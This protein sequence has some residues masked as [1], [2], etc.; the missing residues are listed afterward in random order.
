MNQDTFTLSRLALCVGL[1]I[2]PAAATAAQPTDQLNVVS[3][4]Q[5]QQA[6]SYVISLRT[7]AAWE[8][9]G[10][11]NTAQKAQENLLKHIRSLDGNAKLLAS[12]TKL[13]N[14]MEL[15]LSAKA[16]ETLKQHPEVAAIHV[17][18]QP[19]LEVANQNLALQSV[20]AD[21]LAKAYSTAAPALSSD[22]NAGAGVTIAILS[23][24][25]DY[26]HK[27]LGGDGTAESYALARE[28]AGAPFDGFPTEVV[29]GGLDVSP[30][31]GW[32][33]DLNPLDQNDEYIDR[34]GNAYPTGRGTMLASLVRQ[35][36]PGAKLM[37]YKVAGMTDW[38]RPSYPSQPQIA[39]AMEHAVESGADIIIIDNYLYGGHF[40]AYFDP[41]DGQS[42]GSQG[43]ISMINAAA[44]KGALVVTTAGYFGQFPSKYNIGTLGA[45]ADALTVGGVDA[46]GDLLMTSEWTPHGPVRGIG[47][48]KPDVVSYN[49]EMEVARVGA[50]DATLVDSMPD[51]AVARIA[52][53]AAIVKGARDGLSSIEVKALLANT[54]SHNIQRGDS[55]QNASVTQI[56]SGVENIDAAMNSPL[57]VWEKNSYQPSLKFGI[58]EVDGVHRITKQITL[59]NLS[60][61]VQT[62]SLA[63]NVAEHHAETTGFRWEL[64]A[65]VTIPA[66]QSISVPV[67]LELNSAELPALGLVETDDY[68]IESWERAEISGYLT[69]TS[70]DKPALNLGWAVMPRA[71][72]SIK[73]N[74]ETYAEVFSWDH[75]K[76]LPWIGTNEARKQSFTNTGDQPMKVAALPVMHSR[77][78]RPEDKTDTNNLLKHVGSAVVPEALCSSGNKLVMGINLHQPATIAVANYFERGD[79]LAHF[80]IL[81]PEAVAAYGY[82]KA[83]DYMSDYLQ[84]SDYVT[85]ARITLDWDGK[86]QTVYTDHGMEYDWNNPQARLKTS[87]LPTYFAAESSTVVS[88]ICLENL[89]HHEIASI[90][91]FDANLGFTFSTD[92][93][94]IPDIGEPI[95]QF[96]PVKK[97]TDYSSTYSYNHWETGEL[98]TVIEYYFGTADVRFNSVDAEGVEG[99][100]W[101]WSM[102]L[103]PGET[104]MLWANK[105]GWCGGGGIG[106]V[107][108][109]SAIEGSCK[110]ADFMLMDLNS[111]FTLVAP[112]TLQHSFL[113]NVVPGQ[114]FE[115]A[116]DA[117]AGSVIGKV[118]VSIPGFFGIG[119]YDENDWTPFEI[120]LAGAIP[121]NPVEIAKDGTITV[122][123]PDALDFEN[124]TSLTLRVT[125]SQGDDVGTIEE[126]VINILNVNDTAPI[127]HGPLPSIKV[128][129]GDEVAV[130]LAGLF[131]DPDGDR[132][133]V[134]VEGL[135]QGLSFNTGNH[136]ISGA[137][138]ES[139]EFT[140]TVTASDGEHVI[141]GTM[142]VMVEA[143]PSN[144]SGSLGFGLPLLAWLMFRRRK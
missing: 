18:Q 49:A 84:D 29:V 12:S 75:P 121:G 52:A 37:A 76:P 53:A 134:R 94:A 144:S 123:N 140:A 141:T 48:L 104:A 124:G 77:V 112:S 128:M 91:D 32:G 24:G 5:T 100:E 66:N 3:A 47:T 8:K 46:S 51:F 19:T 1:A 133:D 92:R 96:N 86:P 82:D 73:R 6:D 98:I 118:E 28:N 102:E 44:A 125:T 132:V 106:P 22:E 130:S 90:D 65:S 7:P 105:D 30:E 108:T 143:R 43:D 9:G 70:G 89:Y 78:T 27:A 120:S 42:S 110:T 87:Q 135:P 26:T 54:A 45:A 15:A 23:T 16:L 34:A 56:G 38:G 139:G 79:Q 95:I 31:Q 114:R 99:D 64:P 10:D 93:D 115:V 14:T 119:A 50:G 61:E 72:G 131:T 4:P 103:A 40:A 25:I 83:L 136:L 129:Q 116:E 33:K 17:P 13:I 60:D 35:H 67:V 101:T 21:L 69:L 137:P 68:G 58:L 11:L 85:T 62:Y 122:T 109:Q 71:K 126:V 41:A 142:T 74:F 63:A 36:A 138:K 59:R 57:V 2:S 55:G 111:D 97:G 88:Q 81:T 107:S 113:A 127:Q 20:S 117:A 80:K 39:E